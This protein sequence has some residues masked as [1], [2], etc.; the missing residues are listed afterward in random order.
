M[1]KQE[2]AR[3]RVGL[4]VGEEEGQTNLMNTSTRRIRFIE[5]EIKPIGRSSGGSISHHGMMMTGVVVL[6]G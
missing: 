5:R 1:R 3:G 6:C 2:G 4:K